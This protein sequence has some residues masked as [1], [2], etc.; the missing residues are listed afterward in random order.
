MYIE[1]ITS[2]FIGL[3]LIAIIFGPNYKD[4]IRLYRDNKNAKRW[5]QTPDLIKMGLYDTCEI[6]CGDWPFLKGLLTKF[7]K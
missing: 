1:I 5:S 3:V 6:K 2:G 4:W 7:L